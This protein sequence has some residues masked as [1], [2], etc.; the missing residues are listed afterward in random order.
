MLRAWRNEKASPVLLPFARDVVE[1]LERAARQRRA[2]LDAGGRRGWSLAMQSW[3]QLDLDRVRFALSSYRRTRLFKLQR[4]FFH[5]AADAAALRQAET[6]LSAGELTFLVRFREMR[7]AHLRAA[8]LQHMPAKYQALGGGIVAWGGAVGAATAGG[9]GAA[10][11]AAAAAG[12]AAAAAAA[13]A[14]GGGAGGLGGGMP[15]GDAQAARQLREGPSKRKHVVLHVLEVDAASNQLEVQAGD[16]TI[17]FERGDTFIASFEDVED[18]VRE[19][20]VECR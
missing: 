6:L 5:L 15:E 14:A 8:V 19:G 7:L 1:P 2:E 12:A 4:W 13:A 3:Y 16:E 9:A 17:L 11:A 10:V 20:S 18:L